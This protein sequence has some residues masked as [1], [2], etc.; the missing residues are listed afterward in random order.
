[1]IASCSKA[2]GGI[3]PE[4]KMK[5]VMIDVQLAEQMMVSNY[6]VYP[7]STHKAALLASVF[8]KHRITQAVYDSSL[9]WY[10]KNL[11]I[12]L[13]VLDL[14]IKDVDVRISKL[15]NLQLQAEAVRTD[16]VNIWKQG[17]RFTFNPQAAFNATVFNIIPE[18]G[19]YVSGS[20]F[21]FNLKIWGIDPRLERLPA[22]K[23]AAEL[24]DTTFILRQTIPSDGFHSFTL[25][26]LPTKPIRRVY[27]YLRIDKTQAPYY[28]IYV[29]SLSLVRLNYGLR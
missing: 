9:V 28:K 22:I 2:P 20:S 29:D 1:M 17:P 25:K 13:Q 24:S 3:L 19:A 6:A 5:D 16:S 11:N 8:R 7:D 4:K 23:I 27:G 15:G 10:G 26:T 12:M 18:T 14:A 21:V